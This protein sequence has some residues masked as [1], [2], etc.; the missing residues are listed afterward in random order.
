[1]SSKNESL[2]LASGM[3]GENQARTLNQPLEFTRVVVGD[4]NGNYPPLDSALTAL[5]N[6]R[7]T[8]EILT[9]KLDPGNA[10]QRIIEM[11]IP[12][13]LDF[14]AIELLLYAKYGETEF[15]HTYF[16]LAAPFPVRTIE[17]GGSQLKL[18]Y[19]I[20]VSQY[21]DF[22]VSISPN[23]TY[24]TTAQLA[25]TQAVAIVA[26]ENEAGD[27]A[28][29]TSNKLHI[30]TRHADLKIPD[31]SGTSFRLM[32]DES[33]DLASG[34]CR[35]FAP[36]GQ[37]VSVNGVMSDIANFKESGVVHHVVK[38]NGIWKI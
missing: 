14:E 13:S 34:K 15:A 3:V 26:N 18:K 33:V 1:M 32:I 31:D 19:T 17:N 29:T 10:N 6:E 5:V 27:E 12:P 22:S 20:R 35:L 21:S 28:V 11:S 2:W 9:H 24:L 4:G 36:S 7:L 30:F 23:L 25:D 8:G 38:V 37:K 16:R